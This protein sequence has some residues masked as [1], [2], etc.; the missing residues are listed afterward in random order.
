MQTVQQH[1]LYV[2]HQQQKTKQ[3]I[4]KGQLSVMGQ[5]RDE[6]THLIISQSHQ[7]DV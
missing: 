3:N 2:I 6:A 5:L 7:D 4:D 1:G